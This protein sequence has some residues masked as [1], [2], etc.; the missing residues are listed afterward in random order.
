[1]QAERLQAGGIELEVIRG[2]SG[3][4]V[5]LLHGPTTYG[6][7]TPFLTMLGEAASIVAPSHPG[8]G[9]SARPDG[10]ETVYDLVRCYQDVIDALP[11]ENIILIGCSFGGWLA[12]ELAVSY[13]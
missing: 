1:M 6:P 11:D 7:D 13:G 8:F 10:F 3:P 2:G 5:L 9:E 12:A 4:T